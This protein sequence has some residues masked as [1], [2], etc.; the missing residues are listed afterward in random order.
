MSGAEKDIELFIFT[1]M[2]VNELREQVKCPKCFKILSKPVVS[3]CSHIYCS[4]CFDC[5]VSSTVPGNKAVCPMCKVVMNKRKKTPHQSSESTVKFI[6]SIENKLIKEFQSYDNLLAKLVVDYTEFLEDKQQ[7]NIVEPFDVIANN[8]PALKTYKNNTRVNRNEHQE[9]ADEQHSFQNSQSREDIIKW[10]T[11]NK[12]DFD[13]LTQTTM[14]SDSSGD[15]ISE[16]H[17]K[18][19]VKRDAKE[20]LMRRCKSFN[21][22]ESVKKTKSTL[23]RRSTGNADLRS[24]DKVKLI[25]L[26]QKMEDECLDNLNKEFTSGWKRLKT[27]NRSSKKKSPPLKKLKVQKSQQKIMK[28]RNKAAEASVSDVVKLK[29]NLS[30]TE[31][32]VRD[33]TVDENETT[34]DD[35]VVAVVEKDKSNLNIVKNSITKR[36]PY[37]HL[38]NM[39]T[40][41]E[42][43]VPQLIGDNMTQSEYSVF[44]P[45]DCRNADNNKSNEIFQSKE[46]EL[47]VNKSVENTS[48]DDNELFSLPTQKV[49]DVEDLNTSYEDMFNKI[50][51]KIAKDMSGAKASVIK[52]VIQEI[53][54][55]ML[56]LDA[57]LKDND[58]YNI[59]NWLIM[60]A[61]TQTYFNHDERRVETEARSVQ[62]EALAVKTETRTIQTEAL[63][64]AN[65]CTQTQKTKCE[66]CAVRENRHFD[67]KC[68]QTVNN[69]MKSVFVQT[70]EK[71]ET[72]TLSENLE[73][74]NYS[75]QQMLKANVSRPRSQKIKILQN[76]DF[77]PPKKMEN[78]HKIE[79]THQSIT[80]IME[81]F[82]ITTLELNKK[83]EK[84]GETQESISQIMD[85]LSKQ[86]DVLQSAVI[87]IDDTKTEPKPSTSKDIQVLSDDDD[88][89]DAMNIKNAL[90]RASDRLMHSTPLNAN[91]RKMINIGLSAIKANDDPLLNALIQ[92]SLQN[93]SQNDLFLTVDTQ[94][95][96]RSRRLS[97]AQENSN[98]N[99][100]R[101]RTPSPESES[102][103]EN[104]FKRNNKRFMQEQ[105]MV[106]FDTQSQARSPLAKIQ[107]SCSSDSEVNMDLVEEVW[108]KFDKGMLRK[109]PKKNKNK[110]LSPKKKG[111]RK[112]DNIQDLINK[113][114]L[115]VDSVTKKLNKPP[116][117]DRFDDKENEIE[118]AMAN[119][120]SDE[121]VKSKNA[122][123]VSGSDEELFQSDAEIDVI[124]GTP[125][126]YKRIDRTITPPREFQ[127]S[128]DKT[129]VPSTPPKRNIID[130]PVIISQSDAFSPITNLMSN[131]T[132][133]MPRFM[134]RSFIEKK[135]STPKAQCN[136]LSL[137]TFMKKNKQEEKITFERK[138]PNVACTRLVKEQIINIMAMAQKKLITYSSNFSEKVTHMIVNTND[139]NQ[140]KDD[141]IKYVNA[142]ASGAWVLNY[143]WI[144]DCLKHN[145]IIPEIHYEVLD[146]SGLPGPKDSRLYSKLKPLFRGFKIYAAPPFTST[147]KG[148]LEN[149]ITKLGG[150][151]AKYIDEFLE[152]DGDICLI[153]TES[154]NTQQFNLYGDWLETLKVITVDLEWLSRSV[155]QYK[156]VSVRKY[157]L[158][159]DEA[160]CDLGYPDELMTIDVTQQSFM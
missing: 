104:K 41:W 61:S 27:L 91:K 126:K 15:F 52:S 85:N 10:L 63:S 66:V 134:S 68:I 57:I 32:V 141:T 22:Q 43:Q 51:R 108:K 29:Q 21:E 101:I 77:T 99:F 95:K 81:N 35:T 31:T 28:T 30:R 106:Q 71:D 100:K 25:H 84:K 1:L 62:T 2:K 49:I 55:L 130:S 96:K 140:V 4:A 58:Y 114:D 54:P 146:S 149:V 5:I 148:D 7:D 117:V 65:I 6:N 60:D 153:V 158:C 125:S 72:I 37:V 122:T 34:A 8:R 118:E 160:I 110:M 70:N 155:G 42:K 64:V 93:Q 86:S 92:T 154:S 157:A 87:V 138:Q 33:D 88:E 80:Q 79:D 76:I 48:A 40:F 123:V 16:S 44:E 11:D 102:D 36:V 116:S 23:K 135:C 136:Q 124:E 115:L 39:E 150:K 13:R 94:P 3:N 17:K 147:T 112:S 152:K 131:K 89:E 144:I 109:S 142:V 121:S 20:K 59:K 75:T 133:Q 139:E 90:S 53:Q 113:C 45:N 14:N 50:E 18:R 69:E 156:L 151:V 98:K 143:Q 82:D 129:L 73:D 137:K 83:D 26:M 67:D 97:F 107:L 127:D 47:V 74:F 128:A 145:E 105:V 120:K 56:Q 103:H 132:L 46:I 119:F 78:R 159:P 38:T 111:N 24:K 19:K 12:N 9:I